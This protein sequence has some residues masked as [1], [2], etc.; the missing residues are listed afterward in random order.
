VVLIT[1]RISHY[2]WTVLPKT[3]SIRQ[4]NRTREPIPEFWDKFECSGERSASFWLAIRST[5]STMV[6]A[7]VW[8]ISSLTSL[9]T[10]ALSAIEQDTTVMVTAN[11]IVN[12]NKILAR[13]L[14]L[15]FI[16][17]DLRFLEGH[18]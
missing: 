10:E 11:S 3:G 2:S 9:T 1:S 12:A 14:V 13:L 5:T 17:R 7:D 8:T 16:E 6:S 18:Q 15:I 4:S